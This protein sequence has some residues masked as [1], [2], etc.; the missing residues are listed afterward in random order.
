[1]STGNER[2]ADSY[3][4]T[5]IIPALNEAGSLPDL[6]DDLAQQTGVASEVIVADGGSTDTTTAIAEQAG[7]RVIVSDKGRGRQMNAAAAEAAHDWL[8]FLHA[9]SRLTRPNQLRSALQQLRNTGAR[10]AGHFTLRFSGPRADR[11]LYRYMAAKTALNR[12][13]CFNGD[14]GL[15]LPRGFFEALGGFDESLGFL[16]DQRLGTAIH[17]QGRW[18]TLPGTLQTDTRRFDRQGPRRQWFLMVLIMGA[19]GSPVPE[20]LQRAPEIYRS[21]DQSTSLRLAPHFRLYL[22]IMRERGWRGTLSGWLGLGAF[23]ARHIW[24]L[25]LFVDVAMEPLRQNRPRTLLSF[26]EKRLEWIS[27][28]RL[29]HVL[30]ALIVATVM[31]GVIWPLTELLEAIRRRLRR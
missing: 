16:E 29:V 21:H 30:C 2:P 11:L 17:E 20:F 25:F 23:A 7:A 3:P 1:M 26:Y 8:L 31:F 6:L 12:R 14:Q 19:Y 5:I 4:L 15:L 10:C 24:Q 9:D 22:R 28:L 27:R 13:E 18:I